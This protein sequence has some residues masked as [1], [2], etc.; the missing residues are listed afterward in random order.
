MHEYSKLLA[1][2]LA[3]FK[4]KQDLHATH[5]NFEVLIMLLLSLK[6]ITISDNQCCT[7]T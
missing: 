4:R 2:K 3:T 1:T 5:E 7:G 6:K